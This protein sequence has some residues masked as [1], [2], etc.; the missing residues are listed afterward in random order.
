MLAPDC[1]FLI[2]QNLGGSGDRL[3]NGVPILY[4]RDLDCVYNSWLCGSD[5]WR[6]ACSLCLFLSKKKKKVKI[7]ETNMKLLILRIGLCS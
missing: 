6:G 3:N 5:Q 2:I 1:S 7:S 4:V